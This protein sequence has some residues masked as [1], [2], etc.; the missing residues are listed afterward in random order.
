ML[1]AKPEGQRTLVGALRTRERQIRCSIV[2]GILHAHEG[3][4]AGS[5][6]L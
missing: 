2:D 1:L 4:M 6:C 5:L 3:E